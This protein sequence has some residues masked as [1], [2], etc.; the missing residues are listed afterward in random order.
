[1]RLDEAVTTDEILE[2]VADFEWWEVS[3]A[4]C[5]REAIPTLSELA[6]WWRACP[7]A[8]RNEA[9]SRLSQLFEGKCSAYWH[10][11]HEDLFPCDLHNESSVLTAEVV[12][13]V[14]LTHIMAG[15]DFTLLGTRDYSTELMALPDVHKKWLQIEK[16]YRP[17]HPLGPVVRAWQRRP[18]MR[19]RNKRDDPIMPV[20]RQIQLKVPAEHQAG[21]LMLGLISE[22]PEQKP[23]PLFPRFANLPDQARRVPLLALADASGTPSRS[24]GKG[25][26]LDL[27]LVVETILSLEPDNRELSAIAMVFTVEELRDAL[28]PNN[29]RKGRDWPRVREALLR[30]HTRSIPI[31]ER[32]SQWFPLALRQLPSETTMRLDDQVILEAALP[33]GSKTG[34]IINRRELRQLGVESSPKYRTYIGVHS[35]AWEPGV[36]RIVNPKSDK[37]VWAGNPQAYP[38]LTLNDRRVIA[39]GPSDNKHRTSEEIN[40]AFTD[41]PDISVIEENAVDQKTGAKGWRV[42]PEEA[43]KAVRGWIK[44]RED[45]ELPN[46]GNRPR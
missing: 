9:D 29:W 8:V 25:A 43:A 16:D 40:K 37:R 11:L 44:A 1:M 33:P 31:D 42:L 46:Q 10:D 28:F 34:P 22:S 13:E 7:P 24:Y 30:A 17:E 14:T 6:G 15:N 36:T 4:N 39:F 41:L 32:G 27:R 26:A 12:R 21:Q 38:V 3:K 45:D 2:A 20:I 35:L 5:P 23:M 19:D 18:L